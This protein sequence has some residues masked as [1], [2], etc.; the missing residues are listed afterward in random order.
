M[1]V[2]QR[3]PAAIKFIRENKM[4]EFFEG[5][6]DDVGIICQGGLYNSVIRGLQQLGLADPFGES[7]LHLTA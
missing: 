5:D 4:N 1:K 2:E 3:F 7:R 6:C